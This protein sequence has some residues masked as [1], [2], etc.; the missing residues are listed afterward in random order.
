VIRAGLALSLALAMVACVDASDPGPDP[1][2]PGAVPG[3][4]PG[5]D[6]CACLTADEI[7]DPVC[8]ASALALDAGACVA[9]RCEQ[10]DG[11]IWR[12]HACAPGSV[13]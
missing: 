4:D 1:G 13:P 6:P 9:L 10:P 3:D 12:A 8:L 5:P 2:D 11:S 7:A